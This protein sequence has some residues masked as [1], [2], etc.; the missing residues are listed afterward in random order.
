MTIKVYANDINEVE[1]AFNTLS[2]LWEKSQLTRKFMQVEFGKTNLILNCLRNNTS[3][4]DAVIE[5]AMEAIKALLHN[6]C[7]N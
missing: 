1:K 7:D 2:E 3:T 5:A 6:K 4:D